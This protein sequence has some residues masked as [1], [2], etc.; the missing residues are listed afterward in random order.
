MKGF[1]QKVSY[2]CSV[3]YKYISEVADDLYPKTLQD[4]VQCAKSVK[5]QNHRKAA[6]NFRFQPL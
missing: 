6:R 5:L 4:F 3:A 1:P 2:F